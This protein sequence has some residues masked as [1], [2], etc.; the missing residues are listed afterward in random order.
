MK[1]TVLERL[2]LVADSCGEECMQI[3]H[4]CD[5]LSDLSFCG[6]PDDVA[7]IQTALLAVRNALQ[8]IRSVCNHEVK[9]QNHE[10]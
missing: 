6:D 5:Q 4:L 1:S 7:E 2:S 10:S 9:R 3:R 8:G